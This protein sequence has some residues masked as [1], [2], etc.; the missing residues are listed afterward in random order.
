M[1]DKISQIPCNKQSKKE[2][3]K[4]SNDNNKKENNTNIE[5]TKELNKPKYIRR[6]FNLKLYDKNKNLI[7][8]KRGRRIYLTCIQL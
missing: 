3:I 8:K 1:V 5:K 2:K 6:I 4:T 7:N